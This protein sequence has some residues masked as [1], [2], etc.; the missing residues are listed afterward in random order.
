MSQ[1]ALG[2]CL[3]LLAALNWACALVLFKRSGETIPPLALNLFKNVLAMVLLLGTLVAIGASLQELRAMSAR[4]VWLL[5]LSGVLGVALAD[6][7]VFYSLNLIGVGIMAIVECS[8]S[9]FVIAFAFLML[10]ET[11]TAGHFIGAG[12]IICGVLICSKHP[13]PQGRTRGQIALGVLLGMAGLASMAYGIVMVKPILERYPLLWTTTIRMGAGTAALAGFMALM[14]HRKEL[15]SVFRPS[16]A[17][18]FAI[19]A[20]VLGSYL[21]MIFWVGGFKY[22][23]S[24]V[25]AM[26]N[27][28][29]TVFSMILATVVLKERLTR[30]K[31][32]AV[33]L[34]L[35]GVMIVTLQGRLA[36][37]IGANFTAS[38]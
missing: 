23:N 4:D 25:A 20:S 11:L 17:W 18:K 34:A 7:L 9:P 31:V 16:R 22:T 35:S 36:E 32:A 30:R 13:P 2:Q 5:M 38:G 15:F 19:P 37:W 27:Q 26:L 1:D 24:S 3:A 28:T 10:G 33:V 12:V 29:A 6:T 14:P 8:Y 21:A